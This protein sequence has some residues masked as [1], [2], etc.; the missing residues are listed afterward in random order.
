MLC[1]I[2]GHSALIAQSIVPSHIA[3]IVVAVCFSFHMPLFFSLSG[4]FMHPGR[5]FRWTREAK[6]LLLTYVITAVAVVVGG[7]VVS[8]LISGRMGCR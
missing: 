3:G 4:Y 6:E 7:T 5:R 8:F 2:L 1:V